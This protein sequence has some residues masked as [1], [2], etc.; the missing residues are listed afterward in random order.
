MVG[1]D[2]AQHIQ[3]ARLVYGGH[4][5][6]SI[7]GELDGNRAN[8]AS[9][10]DDQHLLPGMNVCLAEEI[11]CL[12]SSNRD[13]SGLFVAQV[14]RLDC[15]YHP[16]PSRVSRHTDVFSISAETDVGAAKNLIAFLE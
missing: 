6:S 3:F 10:A 16:E 4:L 13:G 5:G 9:G 15:Q 11:Q 14:I 7:P 2:R 1:A 8:T 12:Q